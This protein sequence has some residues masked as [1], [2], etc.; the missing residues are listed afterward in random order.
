MSSKAVPLPRPLRVAG[1]EEMP[2]G[3]EDLPGEEEPE[4]ADGPPPEGIAFRR[5]SSLLGQ[6]GERKMGSVASPRS[7]K[8]RRSKS[9]QFAK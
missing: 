1:V 2:E 9:C 4:E 3:K 8:S 6:E 7:G 5:G